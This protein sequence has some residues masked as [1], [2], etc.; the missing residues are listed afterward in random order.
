MQSHI[1]IEEMCIKM[2]DCGFIPEYNVTK[3]TFV[4][5]QNKVLV[6]RTLWVPCVAKVIGRCNAR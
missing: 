6:V 3:V 4:V 2:L 5:D 1:N